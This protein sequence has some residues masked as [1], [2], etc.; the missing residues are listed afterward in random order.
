ML[1]QQSIRILKLIKNSSVFQSQW[2]SSAKYIFLFVFSRF[3][4]TY[5]HAFP[6]FRLASF[7]IASWYEKSVIAAMWNAAVNDDGRRHKKKV[8]CKHIKTEELNKMKK[9]TPRALCDIN[10]WIWIA[11]VL[12]TRIPFSRQKSKQSSLLWYKNQISI[13]MHFCNAGTVEYWPD[14]IA[15]DRAGD[16]AVLMAMWFGFFTISHI[17]IDCFFVSNMQKM[18]INCNIYWLFSIFIMKKQVFLFS[19]QVGLVASSALYCPLN[20]YKRFF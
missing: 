20:K 12:Y 17:S 8:A 10:S 1:L 18:Q 5:L 2:T 4:H 11:L 19:F 15:I 14:Q 6:F 3:T 7:I 16:V 9:K 13:K